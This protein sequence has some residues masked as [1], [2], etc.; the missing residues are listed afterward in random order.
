MDVNAARGHIEDA[1]AS[2]D[3]ALLALDGSPTPE[4]PTNVIHVKVGDDLNAVIN[5]APVGSDI[6]VQPGTYGPVIVKP[7]NGR[8]AV[9]PDA[10]LPEDRCNPDWEDV[11]IKIQ[12]VGGAPAVAFLPGANDVTL[13]GVQTLPGHPGFPQIHLGNHTDTDPTL[14]PQNNVFDRCL[15]VAKPEVGGKRGIEVNCGAV[16]V[17]RCHVAGFWYTQ[18]SQAISGYNGPGPF[19]IENNFLEAT[20]ENIMFGGSDTAAAAML[21]GHATIRGNTITK[22][23]SWRGKSGAT[24]KNCFELKASLSSLIENNIIEYCW[25]SGQVGFLIVLTVRN[26]NGKA[27]FTQ[28]KDVV[29][30]YNVIRHGAS[31]LSVTGRDDLQRSLE[32]H[33]V[34][35]EH[36]LFYDVDRKEWTGSGRGF[37]VLH[38]PQQVAFSHNTLVTEAGNSFL[39]MSNNEFKAQLAITDNVLYEGAYGI[40]AD[41]ASPGVASWTAGVTPES[42]LNGNLISRGTARWLKYPGENTLTA[43]GENPLSPAYTL[44]PQW[45]ATPTTDGLPVGCNVTEVLARTGAVL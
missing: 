17:T 14:C 31:A 26:Q 11:L 12:A 4:P 13:T 21:P 9:S 25:T 7:R 32:T 10:S 42:V 37:Q 45:A 5:R 39:N 41:G 23:L 8:I 6:R 34:R 19:L 29:M 33:N 1:Q 2:L 36:N 40:M 28:V 30:R 16:T 44:L 15:V 27:P 24:V 35:V 43:A 20:G 38:G 3:R 22:D 18:D